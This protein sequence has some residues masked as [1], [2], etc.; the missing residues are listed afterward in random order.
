MD[1]LPRLRRADRAGRVRRGFSV[2][3]YNPENGSREKVYRMM[4]ENRIRYFAPAD[5]RESTRL[6]GLI[7]DMILCAAARER[8][9]NAHNEAAREIQSAWNGET[10]MP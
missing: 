2:G 4:R 1:H 3:V 10:A 8:V 6:D 9:E 5:Y 7:K